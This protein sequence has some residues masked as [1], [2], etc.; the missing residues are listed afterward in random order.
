MK[1]GVPAAVA[2]IALLPSP[3]QEGRVATPQEIDRL[4]ADLGAESADLQLDARKKLRALGVAALPALRKAVY[5]EIPDVRV[6]AQALARLVRED[7]ELEAALAPVRRAVE[8]IRELWKARDFDD[9]EQAAREAF[10]SL[11]PGTVRY[12]PRKEIARAFRV[13]LREGD[14][15][16]LTAELSA[17]LDRDGL[18]CVDPQGKIRP[19]SNLILFTLPDKTGWS[20]YLVV[21]VAWALSAAPAAPA[22]PESFKSR[23]LASADNRQV[24]GMDPNEIDW[25][26]AHR[27]RILDGNLTLSSHP[28]GGVRID[29]VAPGSLP[30]ARG[31]QAG[32]IVR[33]LNGQPLSKVD[34]IRTFFRDPA[35]RQQSGLRIT[36]ERAGKPL[37]LEYRPLPR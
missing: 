1:I 25:I 36:I 21:Q 13:G 29:Q 23:L 32:D 18:V 30:A 2:L 37:V 33:D 12:V 24:W 11:S 31:L 14:T 34:D 3:A 26:E 28:G 17:A 27:D 4:I 6:E 35:F 8:K 15:D 5:H 7:I 20:A 22:A 19:S 9:L 16:T 10:R